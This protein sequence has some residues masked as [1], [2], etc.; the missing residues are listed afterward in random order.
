MCY[1]LLSLLFLFSGNGCNNKDQPAPCRCDIFDEK[2]KYF[3]KEGKIIK[4]NSSDK[5]IK[6]GKTL[7]VEIDANTSPK[8]LSKKIP[9]LDVGARIV[10]PYYDSEKYSSV[11][12]IEKADNTTENNMVLYF[13]MY[14][15]KYPIY[16]KKDKNCEADD[17]WKSVVEELEKTY[18][19]PKELSEKP[20]NNSIGKVSGRLNESPKDNYGDKVKSEFTIEGK[21]MD[22]QP[23]KQSKIFY[24]DI[25]VGE[26]TRSGSFSVNIKSYFKEKVTLRFES[27]AC[28][29]ET[30]S[31]FLNH[32]LIINVPI[33]LSCE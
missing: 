12:E 23:Q 21:I 11:F 19:I 10:V 28:E 31:I 7:E 17:E 8:D 16:H 30:I 6:D 32:N 24:G 15:S 4:T 9:K 27:E 13:L 1:F 29:S 3:I 33:N 18:I 26:T 22:Y 25:L 5:A 20:I 2:D 14:C